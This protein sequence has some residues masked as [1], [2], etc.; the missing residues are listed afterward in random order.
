ME[1][2]SAQSLSE[3]L[4]QRQKQ[5]LEGEQSWILAR[6]Q[7]HEKCLQQLAK[8]ALD[9]TESV[10]SSQCAALEVTLKSFQLKLQSQ[11]EKISGVMKQLNTDLSTVRQQTM[12]RIGWLMLWPVIM[13]IA[14]CGLMLITAGLLGW[15]QVQLAEKEV[16]LQQMKLQQLSREFCGSAA[17]QKYCRPAS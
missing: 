17:G 4:A 5:D 11:S 6:Q 8:A 16:N 13:T 9:T 3:K 15:S 12:R 7:Q 2:V 10:T 14:T 1:K